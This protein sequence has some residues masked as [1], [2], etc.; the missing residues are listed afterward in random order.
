MK[1]YRLKIPF[2]YGVTLDKGKIFT[3][4][5]FAYYD[6]KNISEIE[7]WLVENNPDIFEEVK[8]PEPQLDNRPTLPQG[9]HAYIPERKK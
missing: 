4:G 1:K 6:E 3:K 2:Y 5:T 9:I 7:S 8:E